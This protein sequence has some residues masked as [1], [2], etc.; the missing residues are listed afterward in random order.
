MCL[1]DRKERKKERKVTL[2]AN[3]VSRSCAIVE[4]VFETVCGGVCS[5]DLIPVH[6]GAR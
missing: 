1:T 6:A 3:N 5:A 2:K 4:S